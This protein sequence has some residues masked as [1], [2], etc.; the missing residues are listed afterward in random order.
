MASCFFPVS[1]TEKLATVIP[2]NTISSEWV[3]SR[4]T[5]APYGVVGHRCVPFHL[6]YTK[7]LHYVNIYCTLN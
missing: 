7:I 1:D 3:S 4:G 2:S 5:P 6:L